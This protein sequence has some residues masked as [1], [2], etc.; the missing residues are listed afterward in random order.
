MSVETA[1][2]ARFAGSDNKVGNGFAVLF[3]FLFV[4]FYAACID[5]TAFVFCAEIFPTT[6]RAKGVSLGLF[7]YYL[8][9]I[10]FLTPAATALKNIGWK[11]YLVFIVCSFVAF[12]FA[13]IYVPEVSSQQRR[14]GKLVLTMVRPLKCPSRK[15]MRYSE[16]QRL[17]SLPMRLPRRS[18][19]STRQLWKRM[20]LLHITIPRI[21]KARLQR[22]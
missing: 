7:V 22:H 4:A 19:S 11:F 13:Y 1:L 20:Q 16:I 15:S 8:S 5:N 12:V 6:Y 17:S 10:A 18:K 9:S 21:S 2:V 3:L 14:V